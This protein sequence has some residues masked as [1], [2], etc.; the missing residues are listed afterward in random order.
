MPDSACLRCGSSVHE[1]ATFCAHCGS[2]IGAA[3][4]PTPL[5]PGSVS[6]TQS[7]QP[8][9][10]AGKLLSKALG[11][12]FEV[13]SLVGRGGFAEVYEVWDRGLS[14]RLAVKVLRPDVAWTAGML[15]RFGDECRVLASLNHPNIL[16]I[17]WVGEGEG[18]NYYVMPYIEGQSLGEYLRSFGALPVDRALE[19]AVPVL[20]ALNHAHQ[21]GL[22]HRDIKPDNVMIDSATGRPLLVDFG[23]AKRLDS[24]APGLT[25]TGFVV[26]TPQYMSPEQALGQ[27][28]LDARADLYAFGAMLFQMVTGAPPYEGDSSQEIV[29]KHL[30]EPIPV[31]RD[32]NAR[33]PVWLSEVIVKCLAKRPVDRYQSAAQVIDAI[34][35][36]RALPVTD[37]TTAEAIVERLSGRESAL[38]DP[39]P[40]P[41]PL[42]PPGPPPPIR[43]GGA[44]KA[45][46]VVALLVGA[47]AVW[48]FFLRGS[49]ID[50]VNTF[51]VAVSA[52]V[53]NG[54]PITLGPLE[55]KRIPLQSVGFTRVA[56]T[57]IA[58]RGPDGR[59]MGD[60]VTG[61]LQLQAGRGTAERAIRLDG[62]R[63]PMFQPLITNN[64]SQPLTV[65]VNAGTT[66]ARDCACVVSP[67]SVRQSIGYYAL[68]RNTAV[69]VTDPA[70]RK[71]TF[72]DLG[73]EA[74]KRGGPLGLS[75][76]DRD[77]R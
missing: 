25:Q 23:I 5:P 67:G 7:P 64:S 38:G 27:A 13:K 73:P 31:P 56:W 65:S 72:R 42:P 30:S 48:F 35:A 50:L 15:A 2:R 51:P 4:A 16:P 59:T 28:Q 58:P 55:T 39:R 60:S 20:E 62:A 46:G 41:P 54:S 37:T 32:R 45:L 11:A 66:F 70:G 36:G 6:R 8:A 44:G 40:A 76:T 68:Y 49:A 21:A 75:F 10:D 29:G 33:I 14:R 71:A 1:G 69:Q 17:H 26:G 52:Q 34:R 57:V 63:V 3:P 61:E 19:I 53:A 12:G 47:A 18:L 74:S 77:L 22:L 24:S 43:R 9:V